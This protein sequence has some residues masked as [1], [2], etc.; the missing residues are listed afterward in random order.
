MTYYLPKHLSF[1]DNGGQMVF[2]DLARDRYFQLSSSLGKALRALMEG[3]PAPA[4]GIAGLLRR[5]LIV[6]DCAVGHPLAQIAATRPVRSAIE[7]SVLTSESDW[8]VAP[9]VT[10][11]LMQA[12][13]QLRTKPFRAVLERVTNAKEKIRRMRRDLDVQAIERLAVTFHRTQRLIPIKS[14]C[15]PDSLA[16]LGFLF[17]RGAAVDL[18]VAV[19]SPPFQ[20]HCWVQAQGTLLNSPLDH[21]LSFTPIRII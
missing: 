12:S 19:N 3:R 1:C 9:E 16:L 13:T 8:R 6:D 21:A 17:S 5:G 4:E 11:R 20:A 2:L 18:V 10:W 15:L 14:V 7:D